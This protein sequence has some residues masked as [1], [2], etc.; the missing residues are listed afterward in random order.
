MS[1]GTVA[2]FWPGEPSLASAVSITEQR[3]AGEPPRLRRLLL[4]VG[5]VWPRLQE[6]LKSL[7][8]RQT[9]TNSARVST[10]VTTALTSQSSP[11]QETQHLS[12]PGPKGLD[13]PSE[14][15]WGFQSVENNIFCGPG[16][17]RICFA[18]SRCPGCP[19]E[20]PSLKGS[21]EDKTFWFWVVVVILVLISS[22]GKSE[23]GDF[24]TRNQIK[25][26]ST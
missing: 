7:E 22:Q 1:P 26:I 15:R 14:L 20:K 11:S 21:G 4:I 3:E 23:S 18:T 16:E 6:Q 19:P 2:V 13:W 25:K 9:L 8:T 10:N 17:H 5:R 24:T 12:L